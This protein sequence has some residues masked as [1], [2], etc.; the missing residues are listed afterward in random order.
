MQNLHT[1]RLHSCKKKGALQ[2]LAALHTDLHLKA[3]LAGW[4][5][6]VGPVSATT[7]CAQ[8]VTRVAAL[9]GYRVQI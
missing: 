9:D 5:P 4:R 8:A 1:Q 7:S 3:S 6:C 2:V